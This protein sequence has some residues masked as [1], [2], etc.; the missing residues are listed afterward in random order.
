MGVTSNNNLIIWKKPKGVASE[1]LNKH[2]KTSYPPRWHKNQTH[3]GKML[4][5]LECKFTDQENRIH[6]QNFKVLKS[7]VCNRYWKR[8]LIIKEMFFPFHFRYIACNKMVYWIECDRKL[9]IQYI[10]TYVAQWLANRRHKKYLFNDWMN[11][12]PFHNSFFLLNHQK[13]WVSRPLT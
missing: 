6:H 12:I 1:E 11:R 4:R 5:N 2:A 7:F 9:R 8:A 3:R 13:A 10:N